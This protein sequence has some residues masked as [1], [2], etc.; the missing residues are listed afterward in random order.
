MTSRKSKLLAGSLFT[1]V[2]LVATTA[3]AQTPANPPPA[4]P[5][6]AP[7]NVDERIVTGSRIRRNEYT[8]EAPITVVTSEQATLQGLVDTATLLQSQ[9]VAS[10]SF[11]VNNLMTGF[12]TDGGPGGQTISLRG[13]WPPQRSMMLAASASRNASTLLLGKLSPAAAA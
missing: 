12:V 4:A 3:Q 13:I 5:Q 9:P 10:G 6:A 11:Q 7:A 1:S 8:S 2:L